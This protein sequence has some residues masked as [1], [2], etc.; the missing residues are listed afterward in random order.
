MIFVIYK[1][2]KTK[3]QNNTKSVKL[4]TDFN[5]LGTKDFLLGNETNNVE[6]YAVFI[7]L[8]ILVD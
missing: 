7:Q 4:I 8:Q 2:E 5:Y 3:H 1:F 6:T